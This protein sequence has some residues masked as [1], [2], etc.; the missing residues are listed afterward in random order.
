MKKLIALPSVGWWAILSGGVSIVGDVFLILFYVFQAQRL[1]ESG[2]NAPDYLGRVNDA[3]VGIQALLLIPIVLALIEI[4]KRRAPVSLWQRFVVGAAVIGMAVIGCI[5][6]LYAFHLI[7]VVIQTSFALPAW[8]FVGLWMILTHNRARANRLLSRSLAWLG[9]AIGASYLLLFI[10]FFA[11]GGFVA[12]ASGDRSVFF[13]NYAFIIATII[14]LLVGFFAYPIWA[15]WLG[16][17]ML[18]GKMTE[19][20][21]GRV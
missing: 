15:I 14:S 18:S 10:S 13:S 9:M 4:L 5:Q 12:V 11:F 21:K 7:S 3:A 19:R 1:F 16:R 8:G 6:L 17:V 2:R 20:G